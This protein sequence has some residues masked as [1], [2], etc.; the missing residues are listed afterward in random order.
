VT[1]G[2]VD[3]TQRVRRSMPAP[4]HESP[5]GL[6][7]RRAARPRPHQKGDTMNRSLCLAAVAIVL[8]APSAAFAAD[9]SHY[10]CSAVADYRADGADSKIGVSIDFYDSRAEGGNARKYVLSSVYQGKLFQGAVIDRSGKFGQGSID[11]KNG[12]SEL[13]AGTFKLE[14]QPDQSYVMTIDGKIND[15]PADS[16]KLYPIK[17]KLPCVDLSI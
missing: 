16:K 2:A 13:Y 4:Y 12:Q 7:R 14:Q 15:D 1:R 6:G 3:S 17:A 5:R 8:G 11:M 9:S 10:V